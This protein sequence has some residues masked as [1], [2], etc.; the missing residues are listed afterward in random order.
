VILE[1][2]EVRREDVMLPSFSDCY[3]HHGD[4]EMRILDVIVRYLGGVF[5][6]VQ[7]GRDATMKL[8]D[9]A[10]DTDGKCFS[11]EA[12]RRMG[13]GACIYGKW[14]QNEKREMPREAYA[15]A[16]DGAVYCAKDLQN[17]HNSYNMQQAEMHFIEAGRHLLA[18][19]RER[20]TEPCPPPVVEG[21]ELS[22]EG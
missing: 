10:L 5:G 18:E 7:L 12:A 21:S 22:R 4:V 9:D 8:F 16:V 13:D 11:T 2:L 17:G 20:V 15:E 1:Y 14:A 6:Q 19:M 3:T